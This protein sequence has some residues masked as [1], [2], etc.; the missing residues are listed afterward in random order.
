MILSLS[1]Q[2]LIIQKIYYFAINKSTCGIFW[3]IS[4]ITSMI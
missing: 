2:L 4:Q 1:F 3:V